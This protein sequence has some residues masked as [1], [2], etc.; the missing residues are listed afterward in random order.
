[1]AFQEASEKELNNELAALITV[2]T[3]LSQFVDDIHVKVV[4]LQE[5]LVAKNGVIRSVVEDSRALF[6]LYL[7][8]LVETFRVG[9]NMSANEAFRAGS[10]GSPFH[11]DAA[12]NSITLFF[13]GRPVAGGWRQFR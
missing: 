12:N 3:W 10:F 8:G 4:S 7:R 1:M 11:S 5:K 9:L 13:L 6:A 2:I